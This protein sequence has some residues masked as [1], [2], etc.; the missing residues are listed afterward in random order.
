MIRL[1]RRAQSTLSHSPLS[2]PLACI[3]ATAVVLSG[4]SWHGYSV[5]ALSAI[6]LLILMMY[7]RQTMVLSSQ[8]REL[9]RLAQADRDRLDREVTQRTTQLTELAQHLQTAREDE[10]GRLARDL[11]DE[12]GALL[13]AAKLDAARIRPRLAGSPPQTL[14]RLDHLVEMLNSGIALKR[15]IVEDL[16]PSALS[17]LGLVATLEI[18]AGEFA[19]RSGVAVSCALE[20]VALSASA[21]L[22]VYRLVQEAVTNISKYA[23]ASRVWIGLA[24]RGDQVL[25]T[26][27]DDGVGFD[28]RQTSGSAYGLVGMRF[29]VEAEQGVLLL[30]S[31][32]GQGCLVQATLPPAPKKA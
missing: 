11:H 20:P 10:R 16:R 21:E 7:L 17:T 26:V 12:L 3:S 30:A 13:T 5:A 28:C 25:V 22:V 29:R 9:Q 6:S 23:Q 24:A 18:L 4:Q 27:R 8:R 31:S 15:R 1:N 19:E 32:P 14:E 2:L